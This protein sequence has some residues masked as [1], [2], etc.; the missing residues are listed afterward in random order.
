MG[1]ADALDQILA[2][3]E[4]KS[5]TPQVD[6]E[7]TNQPHFRFGNGGQ[8]QCLSTAKLNIPLGGAEGTMSIHVHDIVGQPVLLSIA[9][10]RALG[11]VIDF[12]EDEMILKRVD[13]SRVI[14]LETTPGGHQVFPLTS[15]I[16]SE[17][18][19]RSKPFVSLRDISTE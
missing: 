9:A 2:L 1:S 16:L 3:Q 13:A 18:I 14:K 8:K 15:D 11:A 4:A 7:L 5:W 12:S 19:P 6:V 17:S 10:L